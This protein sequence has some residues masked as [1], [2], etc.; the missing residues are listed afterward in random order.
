[1][2]MDGM[3]D[4]ITKAAAKCRIATP[5]DVV[6]NSE[7]VY[8]FHSPYTTE[9]GIIV[10]LSTFVGTVDDLA[11]TAAAAA[12]RDCSINCRRSAS[13]PGVSAT[14]AAAVALVVNGLGLLMRPPGP[15]GH[16]AF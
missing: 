9:K 13:R 7:C 11:F 1:M 14:A 12:W 16:A 15:C 10:N 2:D 8:T 4:I 3:D 6:T 5:H